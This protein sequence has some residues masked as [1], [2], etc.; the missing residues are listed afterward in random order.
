[1]PTRNRRRSS[2]P[3]TRVLAG[4]S[5]REASN[6]QAKATNLI[7]LSNVANEARFKVMVWC[8]IKARG[9]AEVVNTTK[10]MALKA[11]NPQGNHENCKLLMEISPSGET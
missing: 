4:F 2:Q 10:Q 7:C 5:A 11:K 9:L 1:M 8:R 6:E 3:M